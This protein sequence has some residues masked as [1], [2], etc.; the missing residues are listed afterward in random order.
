MTRHKHTR[1]KI[2]RPTNTIAWEGLRYRGRT[3]G[4]IKGSY[5]ESTNSV[6]SRQFQ[7][8][9]VPIFP[10]SRCSTVS[11]FPGSLRH[12]VPMF[13]GL[14]I[15]FGLC[16]VTPMCLGLHV[17]L[18]LSSP[19]DPRSLKPT[20]SVFPGPLRSTATVFLSPQSFFLP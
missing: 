14:N 6:A 4:K 19:Y 10:W 8:W 16:S 9:C 13:N 1:G 7:S 15:S 12:T 11:V 3:E 18:S 20:V 17:P 5:R 2:N